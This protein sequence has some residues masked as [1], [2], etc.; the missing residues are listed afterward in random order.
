M[1]G[2]RKSNRKSHGAGGAAA[3]APGSSSTPNPKQDGGLTQ[4]ERLDRYRAALERGQPSGLPAAAFDDLL[5]SPVK[6]KDSKP[7]YKGENPNIIAAANAG[8]GESEMDSA[9]SDADAKSSTPGG[10]VVSGASGSG[11]GAGSGKPEKGPAADGVIPKGKWK[12]KFWAEMTQEERQT[13]LSE[14]KAE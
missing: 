3:G 14:R 9:E 12:G 11:G 2:K 13:A 5:A 8:G 6:G 7:N 4:A 10:P 1:G